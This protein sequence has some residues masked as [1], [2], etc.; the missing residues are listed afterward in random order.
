MMP[1][2]AQNNIIPTYIPQ[3]STQYSMNKFNQPQMVYCVFKSQLNNNNNRPCENQS[4]QNRT[5][6]N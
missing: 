3:F 6:K 2:I 5:N 1:I 4:D